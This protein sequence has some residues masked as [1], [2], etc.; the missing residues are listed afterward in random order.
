MLIELLQLLFSLSKSSSISVSVNSS[1]FVHSRSWLK[2]IFLECLVILLSKVKLMLLRSRSFKFFAHL[3][4]CFNAA[5]NNYMQSFRSFELPHVWEQ[6]QRALLWKL[7]SEPQVHW[8]KQ[9]HYVAPHKA[10]C[11]IVWRIFKTFMNRCFKFIHR[12]VFCHFIAGRSS[13]YR[14]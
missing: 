6:V 4:L 7:L 14:W 2:V 12:C 10:S 3:L 13:F 9:K 1:L 8:K 5:L 11:N